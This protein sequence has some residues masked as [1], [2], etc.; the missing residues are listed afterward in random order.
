MDRNDSTGNGIERVGTVVIGGGQA[1]LSVGYHL[2]R[3]GL[4]FVI[5]DANERL[6]HAWRTRWDSLHLNTPAKF[7]GLDGLPFPGPRNRFPSKDE[8]ADY[9]E[10]YA[11]H[12]DL[13]VR[14]GT[15]VDR[16]SRRG[17]HFVVAAGD[18]RFEADN[19]V[20]AMHTDQR[21]RRPA[22]A[23]DLAPEI[24]QLHSS[25][26][27]RPGQLAEGDVLLVGAGN[28]GTEIAVDVAEP[29]RTVWLA[30]RHPG[31]IPFDVGGLAGR[32]VLVRLVLRGVFHRVLTVATPIGRKARPKLLSKGKTVVR[33]KPADLDR[34]GVEQVPRVVGSRDGRPVLED[35]RVLAP[36]NVI[37]CTGY[38]SDLGWL[39]V[40]VHGPDGPLH[41]RG[42]AD[43]VPGLYFVGLEFL[44]SVSS[45]MVHGV[46]RDADRVA[47]AI[48]ARTVTGA[49]TPRRETVRT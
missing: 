33:V 10:E 7:S 16:V 24:V 37:W 3:R 38:E 30:G 35:G 43:G 39:D 17:D 31:H 29:G 44:F 19:V 8:M 9:L 25:E 23:A 21:G 41:R 15:E 12:L 45:G 20:V 48:Q 26:Y 22:L 18:A 1:G 5:L 36:A 34:A 28:S 27:R 13:P 46:G 42:V 2:R 6:G 49:P 32:V 40:D 14:L 11:R 47:G 4:P